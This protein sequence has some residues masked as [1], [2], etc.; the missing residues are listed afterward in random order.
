MVYEKLFIIIIVY[1]STSTFSLS[2][3]VRSYIPR[4]SKEINELCKLSDDIASERIFSVSNYKVV[5]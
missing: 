2:I 1:K 3:D 4:R 5:G